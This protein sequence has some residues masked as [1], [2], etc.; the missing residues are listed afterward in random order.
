MNENLALS[1]RL[2]LILSWHR[3]RVY[4]TR[5][6]YSL[7]SGLKLPSWLLAELFFQLSTLSPFLSSQSEGGPLRCPFLGAVKGSPEPLVGL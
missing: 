2:N 3:S 5:R 6:G 7:S 4:C 1:A